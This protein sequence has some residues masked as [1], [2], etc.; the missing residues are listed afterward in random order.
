MTLATRTHNFRMSIKPRTVHHVGTHPQPQLVSTAA[1]PLFSPGVGMPIVRETPFSIVAS[2]FANSIP[3]RSLTLIAMVVVIRLFIYYASPTRL[4][5]VLGDA[6]S[7]VKKCGAEALE[8]GY[9][10]PSEV[11]RF[12]SLQRR[13]SAINLETLRNSRSQSKVLFGFLKGRTFTV[14]DCIREARDLETQIKI[15]KE[16]P[17]V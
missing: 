2:A 17:A 6:M 13:V 3:I 10:S 5:T 14:L 16:N 4:T 9:L 7:K 1:G 15:L 11:D 8:A 12:N